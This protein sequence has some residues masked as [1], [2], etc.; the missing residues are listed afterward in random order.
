MFTILMILNLGLRYFV[1]KSREQKKGALIL[2]QRM[3]AP[4][5]TCRKFYTEPVCFFI[6]LYG[7]ESH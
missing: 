6:V 4:L 1:K 2:K 5:Y 3:E 7:S